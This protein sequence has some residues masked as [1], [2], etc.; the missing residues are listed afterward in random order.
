MYTM[1]NSDISIRNQSMDSSRVQMESLETA[2][3]MLEKH[4]VLDSNY[5][6]LYDKMRIRFNKNCATVSGS[7]ELDYPRGAAFT[8][9]KQL[10]PVNKVPIPPEIIE[11]FSLIQSHSS[12]GLFPEI[13][14]AWLAVD[15]QI[16]IWD[17]EHR[18]DIS[19][20]DGLNNTII[21]VGLVKPKPNI[22][23][24]NVKYLLVLST[25]MEVVILGMMV[26]EHETESTGE[27]QEEI[28]LVK[29]VLYSIPTDGVTMSVIKGSSMGRIFMGGTDGNL[30]EIK[31][32]R[33]ASWFSAS[34][35]K[36]CLTSS[37]LTYILPTFINALIT[38]EDSL[39]QICIDNSRNVLYTRSE[40]G[41]ISVY[42]LYERGQGFRSLVSLSEEMIVQQALKFHITL[43]KNYLKPIVSISA[44]EARECLLLG[45]VVT[46]ESGTRLYF[47]AG[48]TP[49]CQRPSTLTLMH[50]RLPPGFTG[51]LPLARPDKVNLVHYSRGNLVMTTAPTGIQESI[52]LLSSD[53]YA[54]HTSFM[55]SQTCL[56]MDSKPWVLEEVGSGAT[57]TAMC[58][59]EE[60][61]LV[62]RQHYERPAKYVA[63]GPHGVEI[64]AKLRPVDMLAQLF[65]DGNGP[66]SQSVKQ[67]FQA[68]SEDQACAS[69][70]IL[71]CNSNAQN[72]T[73][74][75][76]ATRAFFLY[77]GEPKVSPASLQDSYTSPFSPNVI[78]TPRPVQPGATFLSTTQQPQQD[79]VFS[80][81]H[82]GLYLYVSRILRPLWTRR[83][84][85]EVGVG[86]LDTSVSLLEVSTVCS[87]LQA[88]S[89]FLE[90][91]SSI[92]PPSSVVKDITIVD[93]NTLYK[94]RLQE[95]YLMERKSLEALKQFI[96]QACQILGFWRILCEH[97]FPNIASFLTDEQKSHL[98]SM[99]F[100][101]LIGIPGN[102]DVCSV[103]MNHL[104]NYYLVD[105]TPVHAVTLK[106]REVCPKIFRNEDA[107]CAKANELVMYAKKKI[108]KED[109]EQYLRNSVKLYKEVI[110]RINLKEVCRQYAACQFYD[111]IVSICLDFARKID[112]SDMAVRYYFNQSV[113]DTVAYAQ[114]LDCY[115]EITN[116]L[117]QLYKSGQSG[118]MAAV[119][120]PR[121]PGY[122]E[123]PIAETQ[124]PSK[125]EAKAHI[126]HI[127]AQ[128]LASPDILLHASVY[129]WMISNGLTDDLIESSKPSLEKYLVR[130]QSLSQFSLDHNGLLWKYHERHG[131]HAAAAD[132]LMKMAKTPGNNVELQERAEFLAKAL[133][134]MRSQEAGVMGH[135]MHELQDLLQ[136]AGVQKAI[137]AAITDIA[138]T[139][140]NPELQVSAQHAIMSLNSNL[141][142]VTEL[143]TNY[144]E[145]FELWECKLHIIE[146]AG[147]RDDHLIQSTW[148]KILQV[149]L[150]SCTAED[151][152]IV[153][154]IVMDK[155]SSL[156][157]KYETG[158]FVFPMDFLVYQLEYI[159][160]SLRASPEI[161]QKS[162]VSM[163]V[164]FKSLVTIYEDLSKRNSDTW[165]QSGD[166]LHLVIAIGY[167]A[168][169]FAR[170]HQEIPSPLRKQLAFK[171]Q[172]LL[173]NCLSTLYSKTNVDQVVQWL[174]DIQ[175]DIGEICMQG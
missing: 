32:Q 155:V 163:G 37:S 138:N 167:L 46:C 104:L 65:K 164:P 122:C 172:D 22:F 121:S 98:C 71:A 102:Q 127:I 137:L 173:T 110:P 83:V 78:S 100:Q 36:V 17:Y 61:P 33:D 40:L 34:C 77:G 171:L 142:D 59:K 147:Y 54:F 120:I 75:E 42:D 123:L 69:C 20:F 159:S 18:T 60:P 111:G 39:A 16:Y 128:C 148:Q 6:S 146:L 124:V 135:Y 91:N 50:V 126:D 81:K 156:Y 106:L 7:S 49:K 63:L 23:K 43:Q 67:Y 119:N 2:A 87:H 56:I 133:M 92:L 169:N 53:P 52:W 101:Q 62:V 161:V 151:P 48:F 31:Y 96:G 45:L 76:W 80:A 108:S 162:F 13:N 21:G 144:A 112:P 24:S 175:R 51:A 70:L 94:T 79:T 107:T 160:C 166:P 150:D 109:K 174:K 73:I 157:N 130:C 158:S 154:G 139:T 103:L 41:L 82:N 93:D 44:I 117:K 125:L 68:Q 152:N 168:E 113:D 86:E 47:N 35:S 57:T 134:C 89:C 10:V 84:V 55:E 132:I 25:I 11:N 15:N 74:S 90:N 85:R 141:Y 118:N 8:N 5:A 129:D 149:E 115:N 66:E 38:Q 58:T 19:F 99:T 131:N 9:I 170:R 88:V 165:A 145:E 29:K 95:V 143:F 30:Y 105:N 136:V 27:G 12:M 28:Q 26:P 4:M 1:S 72:I 3:K 114:R 153:L 140:D 116:V 64:Y 97:H 14:R